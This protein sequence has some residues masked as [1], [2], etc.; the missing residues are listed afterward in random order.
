MA[1]IRDIATLGF[2]ADARELT[3]ADRTLNNLANTGQR[4]E[5]QA[6]RVST[7]MT[8][9]ARAAASLVAALAVQEYIRLAD[10]W[11]NMN[12]RLSLV[13]ES[14]QQLLS[15]QNKLYDM[16]QRTFSQLG[17]TTDLY[18]KITRATQELNKTDAERLRLTETI[19]K[20]T[21][22][23]GTTSATAAAGLQQLGQG[24]GAGV[25]RGE[26]FNSVMENTPRL[27]EAMAAGLG[28]T[29]SEMRLMAEQGLLTT[30]V[31][32]GALKSQAAAIDAEFAK[33]PTTFGNAMTVL[34]NAVLR[35]VGVFDQQNQVTKTLGENVLWVADNMGRLVTVA[36][37]LAAVGLIA[38]FG[39]TAQAATAYVASIGATVAGINANRA[40]T[41]AAAQADL[42]AAQAKT[43]QTLATQAA[44]VAA[45]QE[46]IARLA[47]A[48]RNIAAAR[49][50][51]A[52]ASAAGTQSFALRTLR[53]ATMELQIA[54]GQRA[55]ST[56]ALAVLGGQQVRISAQITAAR[57]AETIATRALSA[58]QA[59]ATGTAT[60]LSR[61]MMFL[62]GPIGIITGLLTVGA[63]A[64]TTYGNKAKEA[65]D[66][67]ADNEEKTTQQ[68]IDGLNKQKSK[69]DERLRLSEKSGLGDIAKAGGEDVDRL[70]SLAQK[71]KDG[72]QAVAAGMNIEGYDKQNSIA[73]VEQMKWQYAELEKA[74]KGVAEANGKLQDQKGTETRASFYEKNTQYLTDE[75][76]VTRALAEARKTLGT[77][78]T[79]DDE[80]R[81][82]ASFGK[83]A[84]KD[85]LNDTK[86]QIDAAKEVAQAMRF[87]REEMGLT[88]N[89]LTMVNAAREAGKAPA[90][91]LRNAIMDEALALVLARDASAAATAE[92]ERYTDAVNAQIDARLADTLSAQAAVDAAQ[93]EID[94]YGMGAA[95]ITRY[96]IAKMEA[97]KAGI[98]ATGSYSQNE[99]DQLD[100][101]IGKQRELMNLQ[102]TRGDLDD[103]LNVD[104]VETF[105]EALRGAFGEAGSA[106]GQLGGQFQE[107]MSKMKKAEKDRAAVKLKYAGD[108]KRTTRELDKINA[109]AEADR[110]GAY[111]DIAGAAKGMF[112]EN[113]AG[114]K[115]LQAVEQTFRAVELAGQLQSLYTHLFVTSAKATGTVAGQ[116]VETGAVVAG[117]TAR[118]AA[119]VPGVF[120]SFMSALGPW[121]MA[122]AGVAIAAVLGGAFS[123]KSSVNLDDRADAV[124]KKQGTGSVFGDS[125]AKSNSMAKSLEL[126][127]QNSDMSLPITQNMLTALRSIDASMSGLANLVVG[128]A[129][130]AS[131]DN[132]GIGT[133]V[134]AKSLGGL[135]GKTKQNITDSGIQFGGSVADLQNGQGF[136][137]YAN[138]EKTKSSWFGLKKSTS[139][140]IETGAL[141]GDL[142]AQFGLVFRDLE[143]VLASTAPALGRD[144]GAIRSA[145]QGVELDMQKLS[146]MD[147]KGE[148]LQAA[149]NAV[150]SKASDDVARV[151][152]PGFD[153]FRK[154]GEGYAE[155]V[156]RVA[157][158]IDVANYELERFGITAVRYGD[159]LNKQGDVATEIVRS[160]ILATNSVGGVADIMRTLNGSASELAATYGDLLQAQDSLRMVGIDP[161]ALDV[162]MV[163]GAGGLG[164]LQSG[165]DDYFENFFTEGEKLA[166]QSESMRRKFAA[167][168]LSMPTTTAAF[169][170]LVEK[171]P[172][173]RGQ[174]L[175]LAGGFAEM[176]ES[177]TTAQEEANEALRDSMGDTVSRFTE[178]A[179]SLRDFAA[180]LTIG[181][182]STLT[183]E[184]QEQEARTQ[185]TA[186]AERALAGDEKAIADFQS[187]ATKY[188][189]LSQKVNGGDSTYSK[190]VA[191]VL[192]VTE[193]LASYSDSRVD[194][195][196]AQIDALDRVAAAA[197]ALAATWR[198]DAMIES[199]A[200]SSPAIYAAPTPLQ[201]DATAEIA[202]LR[203]E[204]AAR[205]E[206]ARQL[207]IAAANMQRDA[208]VNGANTV[209][210]AVTSTAA[211][212][213]RQ[214]Y[215][216]LD[217]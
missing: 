166:A 94:T 205:D 30:E 31:V 55:A 199:R 66:K 210:T 158:G 47:Q 11:A 184:Q 109:K 44:I 20:A 23:S 128:T 2:R 139:N 27:A 169:R 102:N 86:R 146:L 120:M 193:K 54:E 39:R 195:A 167:L 177:M 150:I 57:G 212:A 125:S 51:I 67:V 191:D 48:N 179:K 43:T 174:L 105:G 115:V 71:I 65:Q 92:K 206:Q 100:A 81:I 1:G 40:A 209:A 98:M 99:I 6:D 175:L 148:D 200:E 18:T 176:M 52:A 22:I 32:L 197:N 117:E 178:H 137:Q 164:K 80:N 203:A 68:I 97:N 56:T 211:A 151:A 121:G 144:A 70:A 112:K 138:V 13:T 7:A 73:Y 3:N 123:S 216:E 41:I 89:Q 214:Q 63:I 8:R 36:A 46:E 202:A 78:F 45:R 33:L 21:I 181:S 196:Q 180:S 194:A 10:A 154:V 187:A 173:L 111:A 107:Y 161:A 90:G 189:E 126:L 16:S 26:E 201:S 188:L 110:I 145:V 155:T 140:S 186:L 49:T 134:V 192:A 136:Q 132:M 163:R 83:K 61:A 101:L 204:M 4:T 217:R 62:G 87:E 37:S 12:A 77:S 95:A 147:L 25:L 17:E 185:Y 170:A 60:M 165:L 149:I 168:G 106:L 113:T 152:L 28:K 9:M 69:L 119:K 122:A 74:V 198:G 79:A 215:A 72:Q 93:R 127:E 5:R 183:L 75:E 182:L 84:A 160:S 118:N 42:M 213:P 135:W 153:A 162:N 108:E 64:W 208:T 50:A 129:G 103:L 143:T 58:A 24:L 34:S 96:T 85:A 124:Q 59:L 159:V 14:S 88:E 114:Y 91:A 157:A 38:W 19:N 172:A 53:Q 207:Q 35:T 15:V 130:V 76:K 116:A 29:R 190:A 131:G 171:T 133:G 142:T 141:D 82:R 156:V 104:K